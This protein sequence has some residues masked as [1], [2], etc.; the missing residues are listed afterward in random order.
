MKNNT[1]KEDGSSFE[2]LIEVLM[3]EPDSGPAKPPG[4]ADGSSLVVDAKSEQAEL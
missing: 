4:P 3:S 2:D 1:S